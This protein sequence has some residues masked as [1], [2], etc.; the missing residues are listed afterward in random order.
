M[1]VAVSFFFN[2]IVPAL[3]DHR[4][5]IRGCGVKQPTAARRSVD[6]DVRESQGVDVS[7]DLKPPGKNSPRER[8]S[9]ED[10]STTNRMGVV[11]T[12]MKANHRRRAQTDN[13]RRV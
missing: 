8:L 4:K 3:E 2:A 12:R 10:R 6:V 1:R 13:G 7:G 11:C 5:R 9:G